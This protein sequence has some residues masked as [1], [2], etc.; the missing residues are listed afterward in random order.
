MPDYS[1]V[2]LDLERDLDAWGVAE[3]RPTGSRPKVT[4]IRN[5]DG[6]FFIFKQPK[7][8]REHQIWSE[9]LSS[10]IAGDLLRWE[11]Q[12]AGVGIHRGNPGNLL[13]YIYDPRLGEEFIEGWSLCTQIDPAFDVVKGT[14]HTLPLLL[15]TWDEVIRPAYGMARLDFLNFWSRAL[16]LDTF[17]SNRDRHAENW[18]IVTSGT[19]TARM[20]ALYD[21]GSSMGC[22]ID[23]VGLS[24]WYDWS[25]SLIPRRLERYRDLGRHHVRLD[26]PANDGAP[27]TVLSRRLLEVHP[28]GRTAFEQVAAVDLGRVESVIENIVARAPLPP[29]HALTEQRAEHM[30]AVLRLGLERIR[31]ILRQRGPS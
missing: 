20:A 3:E 1:Y 12:H 2:S 7:R 18:A 6:Q 4:L 14:R 11:V 30:L 23:T 13:R 5:G 31:S 15:R 22:E 8:H 27:F 21:Q 26:A 16:A 24:R 19:T 9:L 17:I 28:A 25:G 10:Y 29:P